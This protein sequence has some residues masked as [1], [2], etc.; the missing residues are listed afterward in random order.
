MGSD[1]TVPYTSPTT[2]VKVYRET[3]GSADVQYTRDHSATAHTSVNWALAITASQVVAADEQRVSLAFT[4][5]GQSGDVYLAPGNT[6]TA[7]SYYAK[8]GPG[9]TF[10]VAR[11]DVEAEWRALATT[12]GGNVVAWRGT[13][14]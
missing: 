6:P 2:N 11:A 7:T 10:I 8:I 1:Q 5:C 13:T 3:T 9:E 12:T 14:A 4:H